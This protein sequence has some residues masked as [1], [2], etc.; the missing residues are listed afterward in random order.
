MN[1]NLDNYY[2]MEK[3]S[4]HDNILSAYE[5]LVSYGKEQMR[6]KLQE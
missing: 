2:M 5:I 4:P 3:P 1:F 6:M